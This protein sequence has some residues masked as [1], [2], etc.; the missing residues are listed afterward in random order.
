M[1]ELV[2]RTFSGSILILVTLLSILYKDVLFIPFCASLGLAFF[3][4]W[5]TQWYKYT[6]YSK[7]SLK[8]ICLFGFGFY[9]INYSL[10]TYFLLYDN[11]FLLIGIFFIVWTTDIFAYLTGKRLGK[12]LLFPSISPKKT[13]EGLI[14]GSFFCTLTCSLL[15]LWIIPAQYPLAVVFKILILSFAAHFG[16]MLESIIKRYLNIKDFSN[17]IPGHGGFLDRFDSFLVVAICT[18]FINF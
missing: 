13:W 4:E 3:Y 17:L 16:D 1:N 12:H 14:G 11:S 15:Y 2:L 18:Y 7:L 10:Y 6:Q 9:F 8:S 5:V